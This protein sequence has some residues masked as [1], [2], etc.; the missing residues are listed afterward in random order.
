MKNKIQVEGTICTDVSLKRNDK[1]NRLSVHFV[2]KNTLGN[3]KNYI[4]CKAFGKLAEEICEKYEKSDEV[5]ITGQLM[6]DFYNET[7]K[8]NTSKFTYVKIQEIKK[9]E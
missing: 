4:N 8:L 6:T 2:L 1:S 7:T 9:S 3:W 5:L